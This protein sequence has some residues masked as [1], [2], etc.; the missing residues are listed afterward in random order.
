[1]GI[2]ERILKLRELMAKNNIAAYIVPSQDP[3]LSEYVGEH[4]KCRVWISGFTGSAGTV[5]FTAD[6]A[7]LW[8]DG[9]YYIQAEKQLQGTGI[10]LFKAVEIGVPSYTEWLKNELKE[11]EIIGFDGSLFSV[12]QVVK[13]EKELEDKGIKINSDL[14]LIGPIWKD[15]PEIPS[16]EIYIHDI[17]FCGSSR[18]EKISQIREA[19]NK[20]GANYYLLSS[21]DGICWLLNIRGNDIPRNPFVTAY[22]LV[23]ETETFLF[24]DKNKVNSLVEKELMEDG[25]FVKEYTEIYSFLEKLEDNASVM[26]DYDS[27]NYSLFNSINK[28]VKKISHD[29]LTNTMKAIKNKVEI[30]NIKDAYIK[31]SVALVQLFKWIKENVNSITEIDVVKKAEELRKNQ[32]LFIDS[33]F[34]TIAAYRENAAMMH[35]N[36]YN[37]ETPVYLKAEGFFLLDS[38]A[39]YING[40]TDITRTIALGKLTEEEKRDFTLVLKS[41][42][43]LSTVK[44][45]YG[46]TGSN[47]DVL[48]RKPLWEYGI[49]YKCGTGHGVGFFSNIH[50]MPPRFSKEPNNTKLEK[51][52]MITIEPGVYKE[53]RHGIRTENTVIVVEAEKTEFGQFMSFEE[54]CYVPIDKAGIIIEMLTDSE[55]EWLNN[56]HKKVFKT[57]SIYLNKSCIEWL[58]KETEVI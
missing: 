4:F 58:S 45:L 11:N 26:F 5:V 12:S 30:Q 17:K 49:D 33:S 16:D 23:G 51:G 3:H 37:Q 13:M 42:I 40:T 21:M 22:S 57:L 27:V 50:E 24:V 1:M 53:G 32:E 34:D 6:K 15:R 35:Y 29:N 7:G 55:R 44:F 20:N 18:S 28:I 9:R 56:Y 2:K 36:P 46:A 25:I 47:L 10:E 54:L 19:M 39:H 43:A 8:T 38:G 41:V 52:M 48:A 31:D 14:D